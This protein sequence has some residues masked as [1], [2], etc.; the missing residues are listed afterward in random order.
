MKNLFASLAV[1]VFMSLAGSSF[2]QTPAPG[3]PVDLDGK[4]IEQAK[5]VSKE[6]AAKVNDRLNESLHCLGDSAPQR[7]F[8]QNRVEVVAKLAACSG[9]AI[10]VKQVRVCF[11]D[12]DR[13]M[14]DILHREMSARIA[15]AQ[16]Q[17]KLSS[18][19]DVSPQAANAP[20]MR[21]R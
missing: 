3:M 2:A 14:K 15:D 12:A 9:G 18:L 17:K 16:Q 6:F 10:S 11:E 8:L 20:V 7:K 5:A 1:V 4:T 19:P 21:A 13:A